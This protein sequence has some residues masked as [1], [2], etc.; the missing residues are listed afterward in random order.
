VLAVIVRRSAELGLW[1]TKQIVTRLGGE[2]VVDSTAGRGAT[3]TVL[4]PLAG[5]EA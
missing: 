3:F 2:I 5:P 4:L 1:I